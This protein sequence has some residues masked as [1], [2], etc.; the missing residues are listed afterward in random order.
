ME[1]F[2]QDDIP[3]EFYLEVHKIYIQH[4]WNPKNMANRSNKMVKLFQYLKKVY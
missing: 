3:T 4:L 2:G 1:V